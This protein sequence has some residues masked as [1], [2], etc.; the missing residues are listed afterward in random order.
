MG[1][2]AI[3]VASAMRTII[4]NSVGEM[5]P[6]SS[7][8]FKTMSSISPRVFINTPSPAPARHPQPVTRAATRRS[9]NLPVG[10]TGENKAANQPFVDA[11]HERDLGTH[12]GE[13]EERRK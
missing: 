13:S 1:V 5:T 12:A 7:P 6:S 3:V 10:S 2:V 8:T 11:G 9:A 4:V